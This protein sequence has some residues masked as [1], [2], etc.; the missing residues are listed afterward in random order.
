MDSR[1]RRPRLLAVLRA[2]LYLSATFAA[3]VLL[4]VA[5]SFLGLLTLL[6]L[7]SLLLVGGV[8][9]LVVLAV[10]GLG[11]VAFGSVGLLLV[12]VTRRIDRYLVRT[13]RVPS[14]LERVTA[15]YLAGDIDERELE[16]GIERAL[17]AERGRHRP[18]SPA[19]DVDPVRS[20]RPVEVEL[21]RGRL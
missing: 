11:L 10:S 1:V 2:L 21:E 15:S 20:S 6:G 5:L 14:P 13:A 4:S 9:E 18:P 8:S 17:L 3:V 19:S 7:V 12:T 16:R